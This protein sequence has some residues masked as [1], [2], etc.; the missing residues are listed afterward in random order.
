MFEVAYS[1][2]GTLKGLKPRGGQIIPRCNLLVPASKRAFSPKRTSD[3]RA[4]RTGGRFKSKLV[5]LHR[6]S[7]GSQNS[8]RHAADTKLSAR[9]GADL[10]ERNA[11]QMLRTTMPQK[12]QDICIAQLAPMD[13]FAVCSYT[14][15]IFI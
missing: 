15:H 2:C 8:D 9:M 13:S 4:T 12:T 14:S 5:G 6:R 1:L 7:A 11:M 10:G 3:P